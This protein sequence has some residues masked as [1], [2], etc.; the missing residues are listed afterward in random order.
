MSW[1]GVPKKENYF[2]LF[3]E[4]WNLLVDAVDELYS[5]LQ[6]LPTAPAGA[7]V[8]GYLYGNLLPAV[9]SA[10]SLGSP[11][12]Q[13]LNV[14]A[15]NVFADG[16]PVLKD[17][18]PIYVADLL[19]QAQETLKNVLINSVLARDLWET[20]PLLIQ[21]DVGDGAL[22]VYAPP[23]FY[24]AVVRGWYAVST[25]AGGLAQLVGAYTLTPVALIPLS[26]PSTSVPDIFLRLYYE[27]PL[28]LYYTGATVGSYLQVLVNVLN[29]WTGVSLID[30]S[31]LDPFDPTWT[32]P[33]GWTYVYRFASGDEVRQAFY[34]VSGYEVVEGGVL[35]WNLPPGK[36]GY[37]WHYVEGDA[38]KKMA[39]CLKI[40]PI[41][42]YMNFSYYIYFDSYIA[43]SSAV[44]VGFHVV[45]GSTTMKVKDRFSGG[46]DWDPPIYD[47]TP[48]DDWIVVVVENYPDRPA[49]LRI[50]NRNKSLLFQLQLTR[51]STNTTWADA[52][53]QA[54][55]G[56][57][58]GVIDVKIDWIAFKY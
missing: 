34:D 40:R 37:A 54:D 44:D 29:E 16:K 35:G 9:D 13:F 28:L 41:D 43:P 45:A 5:A 7:L 20:V 22:Q 46:G 2:P 30:P 3:A 8:G 49:Y 25:G 12:L 11:D 42:V 39:V 15:R 48:P 32:P 58:F 17:G 36:G 21:F 19:P 27:E 1:K 10:Y 33:D 50:Y 51:G 6:T 55:N 52:W 14:Y 4:D 53:F 47:F 26:V 23:P 24:R 38:W 31:G 57:E 56:T 18:D